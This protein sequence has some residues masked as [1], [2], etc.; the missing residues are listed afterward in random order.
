MKNILS[1]FEIRNLKKVQEKLD[2]FCRAGI[3]K[4]HFVSDFDRTLTKTK[5]VKN[6]IVTTWAILEDHLSKKGKKEAESLYNY[7]RPLEV[8]GKM[9]FK[10]ADFWW[11][12]ALEIFIREKI[13]WSDIALDVENRMPVRDGVS[14]LFE[15]CEKSKIPFVVI[16]AGIRDVIELWCQRL[17]FKPDVILSTDLV[18]DEAGRLISWKKDSLI[19]VLN[20]N[21]MGHAGVSAISKTRPNAILLGDSLDDAAMVK[22]SPSVLKIMINDP[23]AREKHLQEKDFMEKV[24]SRVD[25]CLNRESLHPVV[26]FLNIF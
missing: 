20:K 3:Q 4:I 19:H 10:D 14:E 18:F 26:D 13:K 17:G 6:E 2:L 23:A 16:S 8:A 11:I 15:T 25:L 21:E 7:Y 9:T 5:N 24:F 12:K 1:H 22:E